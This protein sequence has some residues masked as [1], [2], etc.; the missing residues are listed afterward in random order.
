MEFTVGQR[1]VS[2]A[3]PQLGLGIIVE[4]AGRQVTV[5]FP[6]IE[7][8]RIYATSSAPLARIV[9][10]IDDSVSDED[11]NSFRIK[12]VETLNELC[13]YLVEDVAGEE[14]I[15][16]ETKLGSSI[17]LSSPVDR[18][19]SGQFDRNTYFR[20]RAATLYY[21]YALQQSPA[22]GLLGPRTSLLAH[23]LYIAH[24]VATRFAPRVLLADEVGLGKTIEAGLILHHQLQSGLAS[25]VL[26][27]VPEPLLHQW[28]VEMLRKFNLHFSLFDNERYA[29]LVESGNPNPFESEQLIL[30]GLDFLCSDESVAAHAIAAEWDLVITDEAH[31][32]EWSADQEQNAVNTPYRTIEALAKRCNG[33]LLLTATPEQLGVESHFARLRILDPS[34]FNDLQSFTEEQQHFVELSSIVQKL[35]DNESLNESDKDKLTTLLQSHTL[36]FAAIEQNEELRD[37]LV[38][39][40]LDRHGTGRVLFRNTRAAIKNFPQRI[41][42][43]AALE[44]PD[45]Y[46]ATAVYPEINHA[47]WLTQ[48]PRVKWLEEKLKELRKEKILLICANMQTAVDLEHHLH[49]NRGIRSTAFYE[50]LSIIERDRAAAYF[51]DQEAGA[52]VLICSEIGSEGRNFQFAHH[53]ILFDLPTNP[54][55]L[56]QRIGRLDR[57]GQTE[58]IKIHIPYIKNTAQ[59]KLF[60]WYH[61]GLDAITHSFSAGLKTQSNFSQRLQPWMESTEQSTASVDDGSFAT[62]IS[63]TKNYVANV[64]E[65]LDH[66]RDYLLELNSC[67]QQVAQE[68][69]TSISEGERTESL[70][71]Y[72]ETLLDSLGIEYEHHSE[73][74]LVLRPSEQMLV[75]DFPWLSDDGTTVT[76]SREVARAREDMEYI[77]WEHPMIVGAMDLVLGGELGNC[78]I[79]TMS[80]KSLPPGTVLLECFFAAQVSAPKKL[81]MHRFFPETPVRVLLESSGKELTSII[82]HAQLN[83]VQQHMKRSSRFSIVKQAKPVLQQLF[84]KAQGIANAKCSTLVNDALESATSKISEEIERLEELKELNGSI[85]SSEIDFFKDQLS[86]TENHLKTAQATVQAVRVI[87]NT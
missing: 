75:S 31:H 47:D 71:A 19:F 14:S 39:Q 11:N 60:Y 42:L 5:H 26:I 15:L 78:S 61:E 74:C 41:A 59:E 8:D 4:A 57:I 80:I 51:A 69:I 30:C 79:G 7:E 76:F 49:L 48:D 82:K 22:R 72:T 32:L 38:K 40:L 3:E 44:Q 2:Q 70:R 25:R 13:Y 67:D 54:D 10:Q 36:D 20:L 65:E 18:L 6:S 17:Q 35:H 53:L 64:R 34:R 55:L 46:Q 73:H 50:G 27:I 84:K 1:W 12:A 87:V 68:I 77:T 21:R 58:D 9:F 24:E 45:S 86:E 37:Q 85:R 63:D 52:Q 29:D 83:K 66:G 16:P 23:Q 62:L 56:E 33:M 81:Q 28:L 43:P